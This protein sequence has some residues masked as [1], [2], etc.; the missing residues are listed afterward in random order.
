[1]EVWKDIKDYEGLYQVSNLG[2][3]KSLKR[4]RKGRNN[5]ICNVKERIIKQG[6]QPNRYYYVILSKKG[7]RKTHLTHKLVA[8]AFLNH[9]PNGQIIVVN[10]IDF[11]KLNNN[12]EN[13]E[14]ITQRQNANKKHIKS[15]S[16]YVGVCW[17]STEK[18][19]HSRI[20][21]NGKRKYLGRFDNEYDAHIAY[22][23]ELKKITETI[24]S[25]I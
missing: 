17:V 5:S 1:M 22:Q 15:T 4:K 19:Y 24:A 9:I 10:H 11:D 14:I 18:K 8:I 7:K 20:V 12:V 23:K 3:V 13:L 2:R 21:H 16:K 25:F 6:K